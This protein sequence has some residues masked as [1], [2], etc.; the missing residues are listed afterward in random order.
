DSDMT[1]QSDG[2]VVVVGDGNTQ[3]A[4]ARFNADGNID[5]SFGDGGSKMLDSMAAR[6]VALQP[7][8]KI[9]VVGRSGSVSAPQFGVARFNPDGNLDGSFGSGGVVATAIGNFSNA[10]RAAVQA[11]GKIVVGGADD[12]GFDVVRYNASGSLDTS[13]GNQGIAHVPNNPSANSASV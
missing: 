7:D 6:G 13:F 3:F 1:V 11:D 9:I 10:S 12:S 5:T 2:K 8:G 4:V